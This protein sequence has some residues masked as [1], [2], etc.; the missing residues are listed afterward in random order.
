MVY[1]QTTTTSYGSRV[2]NS[3]K[4]AIMWVILIIASVWLLWWNEGRTIDVA[5]WLEETQAVTVVWS[6]TMINPELENKLVYNT[7]K[8]DTKEILV[9]DDFQIQENAIHLIRTVEMYQWEEKSETK[10]KDNI[11]GSQTDT[12]TYTYN[13]DWNQST[14]SSQEYKES[15]HENPSTWKYKSKSLAAK[16]VF[17][18]KL[19]VSERFI[20]QMTQETSLV[21]E[22]EDLKNSSAWKNNTVS[23]EWNYLYIPKASGTI[24][25]PEIGDL[26]IAFHTVEAAEISVIGQ[27]KWNTLVGYTTSRDT[28]VALLEYGNKT[29]A[30]MFEIAQKNNTFLAW[31]LRAGWLVMMFVWFTLIFGIITAIGKIIPF[32]GNI[33]GFWTGIIAFILTLVFWGWTI[34]VAWFFVRPLLSLAIIAVIAAIIYWIHSRKN[35]DTHL[36]L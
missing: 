12:T 31:A 27:Q 14:L 35:T 34:L 24:G 18:D 29:Q 17:I 19:F 26:R 15:G 1:T 7:G 9:D 25:N 33:I 8:V 16:E 6:T 4:G 3:I 11:G 28:K 30:E 21:P 5:I 32:V 10:S 22:M 36:W 20:S 23:I 2:G 13:K